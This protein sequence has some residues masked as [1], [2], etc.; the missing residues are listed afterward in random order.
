MSSPITA[1]AVCVAT[2]CSYIGNYISDKYVVRAIC[3]LQSIVRVDYIYTINDK[4][5]ID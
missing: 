4:T 5:R 3:Y 1:I 2:V